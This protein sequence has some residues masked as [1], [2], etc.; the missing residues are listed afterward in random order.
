[1]YLIGSRTRDKTDRHTKLQRQT[2]GN[3]GE[4]DRGTKKS[5]GEET[6]KHR[7]LLWTL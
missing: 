2:L 7:V 5:R 6:P 4:R 1:M 3:G